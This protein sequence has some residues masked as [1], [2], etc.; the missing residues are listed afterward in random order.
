MTIARQGSSLIRYQGNY[1]AII[2]GDMHIWQRAAVFTSVA[3]GAYTADRFAYYKVGAM[4]HDVSR[5]DDV[6]TV[7][8]AGR[9]FRYSYLADCTTVDSSIAAGDYCVF[10]QNIEGF[11][12]LPLAQ[13]TMTLS[14]WVK[15]TKTGT[16]CVYLINSVNDRSYI[17]EY[18]VNTTATWE[19]KTITVAASPAAG[20]WDYTTGVGL[21]VGWVLACGST[22]HTTAN[23]WQTGNFLATVNQVN[24]CD[25]TSNDFRF[26]GVRL[27]PGR[28][29]SASSSR[30]IEEELAL[31][32]RYYNN[33]LW[34]RI[35]G[36]ATPTATNRSFYGSVN[37]PVAMR[38]TPTATKS[39][40][41]LTNMNAGTL[42]NITST[43]LLYSATNSVANDAQCETGIIVD[44]E[45]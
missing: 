26:T 23:A 1:N 41:S 45:F 22:Y 40:E 6:P 44:A 14:F 10:Q 17:A 27:E 38:T 20:T 37:F 7:A 39:G 42:N 32:Q 24:A 33:G 4:V 2:N 43:R 28:V 12:F 13:R 8:Q 35:G 34:A 19:F 15:A 5:S 18:T 36:G 29:A 11:N 21:K 9:L 30:T 25:S 16:Y 3:T 31:C